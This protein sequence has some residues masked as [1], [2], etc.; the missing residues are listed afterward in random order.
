M[1]TRLFQFNL[2]FYGR[3]QINYTESVGCSKKFFSVILNLGLLNM[4][5]VGCLGQLCQIWKKKTQ[6]KLK[7]IKKW[8][9]RHS[10]YF[11]DM[12]IQS[13]FFFQASNVCTSIVMFPLLFVTTKNLTL[14]RT[15]FLGFCFVVE[16]NY[17]LSKTC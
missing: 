1:W 15:C 5:V 13:L 7:K 11:F 10:R 9:K 17:P 12:V 2:L 14:I 6:K 4:Q 3:N 16:E 8:R